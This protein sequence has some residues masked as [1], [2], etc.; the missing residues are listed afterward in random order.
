MAVIRALRDS[1]TV[2]GWRTAHR[3]MT[4]NYGDLIMVRN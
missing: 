4:M 3:M 1:R 2:N